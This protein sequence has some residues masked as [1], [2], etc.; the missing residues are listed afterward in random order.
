ML[1]IRSS[2]QLIYH[3]DGQDRSVLNVHSS[4]ENPSDTLHNFSCDGVGKENAIYIIHNLY[5]T[6]TFL[7]AKK[8]PRGTNKS[9]NKN[10]NNIEF[11]VERNNDIWTTH[12]NISTLHRPAFEK[13]CKSSDCFYLSI[14]NDSTVFITNMIAFYHFK[15]KE[16]KIIKINKYFKNNLYNIPLDS[17][18]VK[19]DSITTSYITTNGI[20]NQLMDDSYNI[21]DNIY[22]ERLIDYYRIS[23]SVDLEMTINN[24]LDHIL[25]FRIT[26]MTIKPVKIDHYD[27]ILY[28][29]YSYKVNGHIV[30]ANQ[31]IIDKDM[32]EEKK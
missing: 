5:N 4:E 6:V 8:A 14:G 19:Y 28:D 32:L 15:M 20:Y 31:L 22:T 21:G 2:C 7:Q 18:Y 10:A 29:L 17:F 3:I 23:C 1:N 30:Y 24:D 25:V 13:Y 27:K 16:L 9:L 12:Y 11:I 26:E